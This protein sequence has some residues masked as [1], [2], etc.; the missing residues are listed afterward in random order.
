MSSDS[1]PTAFAQAVDTAV[2]FVDRPGRARW[3]VTGPDRSKFFQN[4][5]TNDVDRL[6]PGN[7]CE[8]FVTS[9]QG[10]TLGFVTLL[11]LDDAI[12]MRTEADCL[13]VVQPHLE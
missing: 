5:T 7:G 10:K 4:L 11:M 13:P 9:P 6:R 3:R 1:A 8:C 12:L 2:A